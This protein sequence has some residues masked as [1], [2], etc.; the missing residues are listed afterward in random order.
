M[1]RRASKVSGM[2]CDSGAVAPAVRAATETSPG[3]R[4]RQ[5]RRRVLR[6]A[7]CRGRATRRGC[8]PAPYAAPGAAHH[9]VS[10]HRTHE[11]YDGEPARQHHRGQGRHR[12]YRRGQRQQHDHREG[13]LH[14]PGVGSDVGL[15]PQVHYV[16][17][18]SSM[19]A[20]CHTRTGRATGSTR[21]GEEV[22]VIDHDAE[23]T[24]RGV[25]QVTRRV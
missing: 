7:R 20:C 12:S 6:P 19:C 1:A 16:T 25:C 8:P 11:E 2:S 21:A 4:R 13:D 5:R 18:A 14:E 23:A 10:W 17:L 9:T 24:R 22:A 3:E 15:G